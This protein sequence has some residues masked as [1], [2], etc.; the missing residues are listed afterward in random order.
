MKDCIKKTNSTLCQYYNIISCENILE[1]NM[2][3]CIRKC[4]F[5]YSF[6]KMIS[7]I[8]LLTTRTK[9]LINLSVYLLHSGLNG[10]KFSRRKDTILCFNAIVVMGNGRTC[11]LIK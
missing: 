1:F 5:L 6:Y 3:S 10:L 2:S 8:S 7:E 9:P 4:N 11:L